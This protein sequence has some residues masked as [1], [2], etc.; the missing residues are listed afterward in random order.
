MNVV[1]RQ[2]TDDEGTLGV[3]EIGPLKLYTLELPDRNNAGSRSCIPAGS[4]PV[5]WTR[6]PRLKNTLMKF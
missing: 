3:L 2:I 4:Y 6:S 5:R 1:L